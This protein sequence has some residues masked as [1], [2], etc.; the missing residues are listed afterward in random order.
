MTYDTT[1]TLAPTLPEPPAPVRLPDRFCEP[2]GFALLGTYGIAH[3]VT[4]VVDEIEKVTQNDVITLGNGRVV[5]KVADARI[6]HRSDR[7][8]VVIVDAHLEAVRRAIDEMR[9]R[10]ADLAPT[11][12]IVSA[13]VPHAH[14]LLIGVRRT[15]DFGA[16]VTVASGGIH[17]E[18]LASAMRP[19]HASAI[20]SVDETSRAAVAAALS[21]LPAVRFLTEPQRGA[22]PVTTL[23]AITTTVV[24]MQALAREHPE[25]SEFEVNPFAVTARGLV[26]LDVLGR[27]AA[28]STPVVARPTDK[29]VH[30]LRP[31][32][33]AIVGVSS[34]GQN[35]GRIIL[36]NTLEAGF[37]AASITIVKPGADA[38]DGCRC[39]GSIADLGARVDLLVVAVSAAQVPQT[40]DQVLEHEAAESLIVIPGG[41]EEK[42]GADALV[43]P[44][45][46]RLRASRSTEWRGPILNG[47]NCLGV[48]SRPGHV[49]TLFIPHEK[50]PVPAGPE[51]PLAIVSQ[52]GAFAIARLSKLAALNPRFVVTLGNQSDL[53]IGDYLHA[54]ADDRSVRVF[55]VYVEG[56]RDG[57]GART[58]EAV[59]RIRQSGR[60][61]IIY[62]AGRTSAG[63]QASASHTASLA[64]DA[65]VSQQLLTRAGAT[66]AETIDDF[67][68]L[69]AL[70][71]A[72][73]GRTLGE[74][75]A[76]VSNAGFEC[77]AAGDHLGRLR[78]ASFKRDTQERLA[79]L[80]AS[81]KLDGLVDV[82]NPLDLTP[83]ASDEVFVS[84]VEA[85]A[86]DPGVGAV[87]VGVV[88][89]SAALHTLPAGD[90]EADLAAPQAIAQRL[91]R[92]MRKVH[93]PIIVAIDSGPLYDPLARWLTESGMAVVRTLDRAVRALDRLRA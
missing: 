27:T 29:L 83:M 17:A 30:L 72:C 82:H 63:A 87:I 88:P 23:E 12:F 10:F 44:M 62:R 85:V 47:G 24:A 69:V 32:S 93:R 64:G 59:A 89:L 33:I 74:A 77:V 20:I 41:L 39:V 78:L 15:R 18:S 25:L 51:S 52:S 68:D 28:A 90:P 91:A 66:I 14:E 70:A 9:T 36:R 53:T 4:V 92:L 86:T 55:A 84:A 61:V 56:F 13:F 81:A 35:V 34:T 1:A 45:R 73:D 60:R 31:R 3:A 22:A 48:R 38:I 11:R 46:A 8:G 43:A 19:E 49:D 67:D 57:D 54:L 71:L 21:V 5:V 16:V 65:R 40:I 37:P 80:F 79:A 42:V 7:G 75:V 58:C 26:A 76:V 2:D 50:L 6:A